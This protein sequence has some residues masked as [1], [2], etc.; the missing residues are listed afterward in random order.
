[1]LTS[2]QNPRVKRVRRLHE[3]K[4]RREEGAFLVEGTRLVE[5]LRARAWGVRE[6]YVLE[7]RLALVPEE[8]QDRV[9]VVAPHVF[10][11]MSALEHPEGL[12]AVVELPRAEPLPRV[13]PDAVWLALD[14]LQDP[15]NVGALLRTADA[16]GVTTV[17]LGPGCA[18]PFQPKVVRA[19]MGSVFH[20]RMVRVPDMLACCAATRAAGM[21]WVATTLE[22]AQPLWDAD[23]DGPVCWWI[24][25]EGTGLSAEALEAA[26]LRVHIP[27]TGR[28]E[29]LNAAA[30]AAVCL[31]E[32]TRRRR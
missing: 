20:V 16:A 10:G 11:V 27:M 4:G 32:T 26:D 24:G 6:V 18:D 19:S 14:G 7:E 21:R 13:E 3:A 28:A 22:R 25:R 15:G 5:V 30:A 29:S 1:M 2:V 8:W 17:V 12:L 23:L 9:T 31:F